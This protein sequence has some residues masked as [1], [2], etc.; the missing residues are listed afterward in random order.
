MAIGLLLSSSTGRPLEV[1]SW[2]FGVTT[3]AA[4]V[5]ASP[6]LTCTA[7]RAGLQRRSSG[8]PVMCCAPG[9]G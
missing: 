7:S 2:P 4:R 8:L 3:G 1:T 5:Y 9:G 6:S